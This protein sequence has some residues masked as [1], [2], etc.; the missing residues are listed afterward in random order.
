M[1]KATRKVQQATTVFL[2]LIFGFAGCN[3]VD[4][5]NQS[6]PKI[7]Q[8]D[9]SRKL[10]SVKN[11]Q[12]D[13]EILWNSIREI[14]PAY[15]LYTPKDSLQRIYERTLALLDKPLSED[16]FIAAI[17]PFVSALK[18]GHTQIRHSENYKPSAADRMPH[19]PFE[20]LVESK[21][22]WITTHQITELH[23][24]DELLRINNIPVS[25]IIKH[26]GDLYAAD[27]DN[28]TFKE[29]FLSEY[30]G[31][32][33]ACNRYYGW[34]PPYNITLRTTGGEEKTISVD[35]VSSTMAQ[36]EPAQVV[37]NYKD[38]TVSSHTDYLPLRFLKSAS[39]AWFEVHSYQYSDTVIFQKA[40]GEIRASRVK[41][42]IIDLRHNTGGDIRIAEKLLTYLAD[43]PFQMVG[44]I[45]AAVPDP[46][47]SRFAPYFDTA[48]TGSFYQS[49]KP[50]G[51]VKDG[52]YGY[53]VQPAFGNLLQKTALN[54]TNH[55][56]GKLYV[57]IDGA[58]FS[59]GAHSAAA[60]KQYCQ[61][62]IFIGRETAGGSEGCSGGTLQHLTLPNTGIIIE[63]PWLRLVSVLKKPVYGH[64]VIPDHVVAYAPH[65]VITKRDLDLE[66]ALS[67][68]HE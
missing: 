18:C 20:V 36:S 48:R 29:L 44:D 26:G 21:K 45:W 55:Y 47:K 2:L 51:I 35:T 66:T 31:F 7:A 28:E 53:D 37:D 15:G 12:E 40:F 62:A 57:L 19:L 3:G 54:K 33:D 43:T 22:A 41:D 32:E 17:Y 13:L 23:T 24:G 61:R 65:D 68:I 30:D 67:L 6:D 60:I 38:W 1:K 4:R 11:M 49:F 58:T 63:F 5:Q 64:G 8:A 46:A 25:E 14:H 10:L 16:E 34:K 9:I 59:A 52:R 39:I 42:L 27:G 50:T 56:S